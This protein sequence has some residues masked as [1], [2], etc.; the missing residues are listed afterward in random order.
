MKPVL[1]FRLVGNQIFAFLPLVDGQAL[2]NSLVS[3]VL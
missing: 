3:V 1:E 2:R